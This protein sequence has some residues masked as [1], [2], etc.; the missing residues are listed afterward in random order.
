MTVAGLR[1]E[2]YFVT[3]V[4]VKILFAEAIPIVS[5]DEVL[6]I[7]KA[8]FANFHSEFGRTPRVFVSNNAR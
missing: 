3:L 5:R 4:D 6:G 1:G 7:I 8:T 2:R